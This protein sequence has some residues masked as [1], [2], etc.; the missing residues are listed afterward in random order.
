MEE[1]RAIVILYHG[2]E[3]TTRD[4]EQ[5]ASYMVANGLTTPENITI[6]TMDSTAIAKSTVKSQK[7]ISFKKEPVET[8]LHYAVVYVGEKFAEELKSSHTFAFAF[9]LASEL[10]HDSELRKAIGIIANYTYFA[11]EKDL[12]SKYNFTVDAYNIVKQAYNTLQYVQRL[13]TRDKER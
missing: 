11:I 13:S 9:K 10:P 2:N 4:V 6:K 5:I 3:P 7:K 8:P 1:L 12:T